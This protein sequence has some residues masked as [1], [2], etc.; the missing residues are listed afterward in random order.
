MTSKKMIE[1][2]E[3]LVKG[4][5]CLIMGIADRPELCAK[6]LIPKRLYNGTRPDPN[7]IVNT[8]YGIDD[9]L[10]YEFNNYNKIIQKCPEDLRDYFVNIHGIEQT[11]DGRKAL[12]MDAVKNDLGEIASNLVNNSR[13]LDSKFW[14]TLER[15]RKEVFLANSID[16]FGIVRRNILVRSPQHPVFIDFQT[17]RERFRSQ[18]WL[19]FPWFVRQKTNRC[20]RKLYKE[21]GLTPDF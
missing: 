1:L 6:V 15:I 8:K 7:Y 11:T 17:G 18:F 20:F 19:R 5:W 12:V 4:G 21:M 2:T 3:I 9:F 16:H 14:D 13:T 10:Q